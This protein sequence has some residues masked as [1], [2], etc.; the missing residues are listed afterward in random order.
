MKYIIV[1]HNHPLSST[2]I[3]PDGQSMVNTGLTF[4]EKR[5]AQF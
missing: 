4:M 3:A 2:G 1:A 5:I